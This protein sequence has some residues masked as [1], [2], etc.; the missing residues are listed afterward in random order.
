MEN[1]EDF[2]TNKRNQENPKIM[3]QDKGNIVSDKSV[4]VK[5]F[6]KHYINIVE[7]SCGKNPTNISQEHGNVSD[8]EAIRLICKTCE[9][10]QSIK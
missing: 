4:L 6:N 5:T 1:Y 8:T 2:L 7:K 9:N 3:L 10:H